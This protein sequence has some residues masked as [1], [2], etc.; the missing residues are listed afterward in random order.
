MI[1]SQEDVDRLIRE[2]KQRAGILDAPAAASQKYLSLDA[3]KRHLVGDVYE[4]CKDPLCPNVFCREA[5]Q[6][7]GT[8]RLD[9]QL[10]DPEAW[11]LLH[12]PEPIEPPP[13]VVPLDVV[14]PTETTAAIFTAPIEELKKHMD[15]W[16]A[17]FYWPA[18]EVCLIAI[19]AHFAEPHTQAIWPFLVGA[20]RTGKTEVIHALEGLPFAR[21]ESKLTSKAFMS[22]VRDKNGPAILD[23]MRLHGQCVI[24]FKDFTTILAMRDD[25]RNE[26]LADLREI[27]D[28]SLNDSTGL[29]KLPEWEGKITLI[30]AVTDEI[31]R[32]WKTMQRLGPRFVFVRWPSA[33][34]MKAAKAGKKQIGHEKEIHGRAQSLVR[35]I[36]CRPTWVIPATSPEIYD[37]GTNCIACVVVQLRRHVDWNHNNTLIVDVSE[38][39][40]P[41]PMAK[42]LDLIQRIRAGLY[43]RDE[44]NGDDYELAKLVGFDS[45]PK[46]RMELVR[47][48]FRKP[49]EVSQ[50]E[51]GRALSLHRNVVDK[52]VEELIALGVVAV[53][54]ATDGSK[55]VELT[56]E[57]RRDFEDACSPKP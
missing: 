5:I 45:V 29:G 31:E 39:E 27:A 19:V 42:C 44:V 15:T 18:M 30:A 25:D 20:P 1:H 7:G 51:I 43:Q 8:C 38:A 33:N 10:A 21:R 53:E 26:I 35:E 49:A 9:P 52:L 4:T 54:K 12:P 47:Y 16:F 46:R 32:S 57:F 13:Q 14:T 3:F 41:A 17:D 6:D 36:M 23:D 22:A 55:W 28:G 2:A 34:P 24:L 56:P 48:L 40:G 37:V 11:A 50:A